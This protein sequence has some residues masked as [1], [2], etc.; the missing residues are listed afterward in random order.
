MKPIEKA[1]MSSNQ[2]RPTRV[3]T[4]LFLPLALATSCA[5]AAAQQ[6][7]A[8]LI[9][10]LVQAGGAF[11]GIA[12]LSTGERSAMSAINNSGRIV[13]STTDGSTEGLA[14]GSAI[15]PTSDRSP[16]NVTPV[17]AWPIAA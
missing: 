2:C 16:P 17:K 7:A 10:G 1:A 8:T 5:T 6:L 12:P 11:K 15:S 4:A 3:I 14:D 9:E 13:G